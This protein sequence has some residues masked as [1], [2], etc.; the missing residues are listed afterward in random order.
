M[1]KLDVFNRLLNKKSSLLQ[2]IFTT[3]IF[4]ALVTTLV[5]RHVYQNPDSYQSLLKRNTLM[6]LILFLI[7][8][9]ALI[10][11]MT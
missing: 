5:F 6:M 2:C 1:G 4:Q 10:T 8:Q 3:L 11:A 9:I 7:V